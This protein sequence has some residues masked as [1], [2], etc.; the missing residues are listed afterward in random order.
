MQL[1]SLYINST[2]VHAYVHS[3]ACPGKFCIVFIIST[4][5]LYTTMRNQNTVTAYSSKKNF[6]LAWQDGGV[7]QHINESFYFTDQEKS[8]FH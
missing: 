3:P 8:P 1:I 6:S 7:Y 5:C 2:S 4:M